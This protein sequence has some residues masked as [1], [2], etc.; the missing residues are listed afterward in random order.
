MF[1]MLEAE[2]YR[3]GFE[4]RDDDDDVRFA[5]ALAW[6]RVLELYGGSGALAIEALSR[7]AERAVLV[8]SN[9][10][11]RKVIADNLLR[12]GLA[13]RATVHGMPSE[14]AVSTLSGPYDLIL[15]DPPYDEPAVASVVER[16]VERGLA[17][18]SAVLIWEHAR[19]AQ[20]PER[21]GEGPGAD[22]WRRV[23]T[24]VHGVAAVSLYVR[25]TAE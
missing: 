14:T 7:G 18:P 10:A 23:K 12:T 21:I 1:S 5:T 6:P 17:S 3:R 2:A 4:P 8:E 16:L 22:G 11:A 20:P 9:A 15:L 24:N 13:D 25:A 19:K